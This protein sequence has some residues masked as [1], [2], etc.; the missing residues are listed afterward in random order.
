MTIL[1][2]IGLNLQTGVIII[3]KL[4]ATGEKWGA[5]TFS[6][7]CPCRTLVSLIDTNETRLSLQLSS[8]TQHESTTFG[9][10]G[11][12][13]LGIKLT[14]SGKMHAQFASHSPIA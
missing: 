8:F 11:E 12:T 14:V 2:L 6:I 5:L 3:G 7:F 10:I 4:A 1:S 13:I 9:L